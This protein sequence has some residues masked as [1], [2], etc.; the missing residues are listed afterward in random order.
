MNNIFCGVP[1]FKGIILIID[2][3]TIAVGIHTPCDPDAEQWA[4]KAVIQFLKILVEPDINLLQ[5][6]HGFPMQVDTLM[7]NISMN[8]KIPHLLRRL[9][10]NY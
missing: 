2:Q 7:L 4:V 3:N 8:F 5:L 6:L 1:G 9:L 10:E